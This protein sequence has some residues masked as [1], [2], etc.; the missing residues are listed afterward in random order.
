MIDCF[1]ASKIV[2]LSGLSIVVSCGGF[3]TP[4]PPLLPDSLPPIWMLKFHPQK[5]GWVGSENKQE[6]KKRKENGKRN[7]LCRSG[8]GAQATIFNY[9]LIHDIDLG[10]L[11]LKE[12]RW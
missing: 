8:I 6:R 9:Y 11:I 10:S 4:P 1:Y 7:A 3:S 5:L 12:Y 2:I